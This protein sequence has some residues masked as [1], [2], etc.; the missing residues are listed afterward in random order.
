MRKAALF[1]LA[2]IA[3][4]MA[5]AVA[6]DA[7]PA[8]ALGAWTFKTERYGPGCV[9]SGAMQIVQKPGGALSCRFTSREQCPTW[10]IRARQTCTVKAAGKKLSIAAVVE[11]TK[12]PSASYRPDDFTLTV[13]SPQ[14]MNGTM[15][16][17]YASPVAFRR[18]QSAPIS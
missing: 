12:P 18:P 8:A 6:A 4:P 10:D 9:L 7:L 14:E 16:S 11:E 13:V 3:A 2:L 5:Q 15:S 17:V 1:A